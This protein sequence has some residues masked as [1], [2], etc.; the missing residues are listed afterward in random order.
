VPR[1]DCAVP[2][3]FVTAEDVEWHRNEGEDFSGKPLDPNDPPA[4][5]SQASY[6]DRHK[7]LT[8][9]ERRRLRKKDFE[10]EIVSF[11][12]RTR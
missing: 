2:K 10:P 4:Y 7:L 9:A 12:S 5:E 6:L 3:D 1:F 11:P 8:P